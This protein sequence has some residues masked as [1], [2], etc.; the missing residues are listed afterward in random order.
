MSTASARFVV[1]T[2]PLPAASP[3]VLTTNRSPIPARKARAAASSSK[4]PWAAVGTPASTSTSFIHAL[5]PSKRA[6]SA[7]GPK[8]R[9]P[10]AL[11]R[12]ARPPTS[13]AS[14]P[15]TVRSAST[16][17]GG[18]GTDPGMPGFPGVTTTSWDRPRT[19]ARACSR[20]PDPT[21][22]TL[23]RRLSVPT[24]STGE[25][26]HLVASR[27]DAHHANGYPDLV[28]HEGQVGLGLGRQL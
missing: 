4:V 17:V 21:T 18:T 24:R 10:S 3:S 14:G 13:G 7:P 19:W 28:L 27:S 9:R 23:I 8:T 11:S 12:S 20:P 16:S 1:T 25:P 22:Q 5:D 2:T 26:E 15:I 6:P